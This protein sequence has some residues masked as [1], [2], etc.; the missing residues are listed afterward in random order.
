MLARPCMC[1]CVMGLICT[2]KAATASIL[3]GQINYLDNLF[4]VGFRLWLSNKREL[5]NV[6]VAEIL[7][8]SIA[9][10]RHPGRP[11]IRVPFPEMADRAGHPMMPY[12]FTWTWK[13][14][15]LSALTRA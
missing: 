8:P 14:A 10:G 11:S 15:S 2:C 9:P 13:P 1:I 5:R 4:S 7:L 6:P 3:D 12:Y